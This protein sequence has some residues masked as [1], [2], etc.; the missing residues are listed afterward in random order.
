MARSKSTVFTDT[1]VKRLKPEDAKYSRSEGN[2]FTIRVWPSGLKT[3]LYVYA[4]ETKRRE[5][6]WGS[7][8]DVT[9]E[10][11]RS[12]FEDARKKF[13]NGIDP[14]VEKSDAIESRKA[15]QTFEELARAY[16]A[17]NVEGQLV[18]LSVYT[19][20]RI[21][22]TSGKEGT[23]D[24]FKN[25]K[26][27]KVSTITTEDAAKLLKAVADRS[28]ASARNMI[29]TARPMFAYALARG[30]IQTNPFIL[31]SVKSFLSK[32]MQSKLEPTVKNRILSEDE[33]R[34]L[35]GALSTA[36]ASTE[37]RNAIRLM[38]LTGQRPSEVLGLHASEIAGNWWTLPKERTKARL[39]K[40]R[41]DHTVFLVPEA[42]ALI[43]G[44]SGYI[45]GSPMRVRAGAAVAEKPISINALG[46]M[47]AENNKYFGLSPWGAHDLRRTCRTYMSDIDGITSNA[48]EAI[49]NHA[50]E[51]T[52]R[53]YDHHKYQRQ[54]ENALTLWR[55]KLVEII[56][57]PL[58]PELPDNVIPMRRKVVS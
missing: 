24:D 20:K 44:K 2:G 33:I 39:D 27:K 45:F 38:L 32:P 56:G 25:W 21:L 55:D 12:K 9:L 16:I 19:I 11:A 10:T 51:G 40:N 36:K 42:L 26:Q 34:H 14:M 43:G 5:M 17:D 29:K 58:V 54:I 28:A 22:L 18:E 37:T 1:M 23:I 41:T 4:F 52:K 49:L 47:I 48:A 15:E 50:K 13:K 8:P 7:Y 53:N 31:A 3:W 57:G 35:W 30:M 6:N 46:H